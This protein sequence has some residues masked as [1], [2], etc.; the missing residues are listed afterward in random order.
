MSWH[1]PVAWRPSGW[2]SS[3]RLECWRRLEHSRLS[4]FFEPIALAPDIDQGGVMQ[5]TVEQGGGEHLIRKEI[6]PLAEGLVAA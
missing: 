3:G 5:Q 1:T 6:A 4:F 2:L